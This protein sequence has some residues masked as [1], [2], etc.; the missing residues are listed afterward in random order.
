MRGY[1][2]NGVL[3]EYDILII[4]SYSY[5]RTKSGNSR[6]HRQSVRCERKCILGDVVI[7]AEVFY[8]APE[9]TI[10]ESGYRSAESLNM[11]LKN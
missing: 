3:V 4:I 6:A 5:E 7:S 10:A 9:A 1:I 8:Q 2:G 11:P